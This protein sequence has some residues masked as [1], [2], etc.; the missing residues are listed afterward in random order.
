[1]STYKKYFPSSIN[2]FSNILKETERIL[3]F[4]LINDSEMECG[5]GTQI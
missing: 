1:M 5:L 2:V 3:I 4:P